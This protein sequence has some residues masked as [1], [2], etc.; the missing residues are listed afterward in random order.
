MVMDPVVVLGISG[1]EA[2]DVVS[3]VG[4]VAGCG[5][6]SGTGCGGSVDGHGSKNDGEGNR[7]G[8]GVGAGNCTVG[9]AGVGAV[10]RFGELFVSPGVERRDVERGPG[11]FSPSAVCGGVE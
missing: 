2:A 10:D 4:S 7:F 11:E 3:R 5:G 8:L 6:V 9:A 1:D